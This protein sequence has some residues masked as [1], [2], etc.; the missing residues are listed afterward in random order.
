MAE[1]FI[2]G[3]RKIC[4]EVIPH[5]A[6]NA[7]LPILAASIL[8]KDES[9]F[10]N[11]PDITDV[12]VMK[13]ILAS[14]GCRVI[15]GEGQVSV[16]SRGVSCCA[17]PDDLMNKMRSSVFLA[18]PLLARCGKVFIGRP[19]GCSIGARP[20]DLHIKA[21][22]LMGA[23]PRYMDGGVLLSA[24]KLKGAEI[25]LDYPSVG[26]TENVMMAALGAEG[27][28]VIHNAAREPEIADLQQYLTSCGGKVRGAG[29]SRIIIEGGHSLRGCCYTIMPDR[30]EAGTYLLA[31]AA[32]GGKI[33]VKNFNGSWL[34]KLCR[35]LKSAGCEVIT[36]ADHIRL[37]APARLYPAGCLRTA[38]YPG[39][40]TD[41]QPQFTAVM[42]RAAGE[43]RV[44]ER[45][46]ES[47]F[48]FARQLIKMGADIEI[49]S[50]IA[51]IK[52]NEFLRGTTVEAQ[53]LRGGAALVLAGLMAQGTTVV[54]NTEFIERGYCSLHA[55][56]N[57]LGAEIYRWT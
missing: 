37:K 21:F 51:I 47:R 3:G 7:A 9:V 49:S 44:E 28:T 13:G 29:T 35:M 19:G 22:E 53:D 46:F 32:T 41:L 34:K 14:L 48:A 2:R 39:F 52:G 42:T 12:T 33:Q 16:D 1:Y 38:P 31:A 36:G 26:A 27:T 10:Y 50:R 45:V 55:E 15:T 56:L 23:V 17:V 40:P 18:G 54:R 43:T 25:I 57:R 20:I 30:I 6:K 8:M 24:E 5:G 11:C 4:G